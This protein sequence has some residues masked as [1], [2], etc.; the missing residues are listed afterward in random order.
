MRCAMPSESIVFGFWID[1]KRAGIVSAVRPLL[2]QLQSLGFR[3]APHTRAAVLK[4]TGSGS[5]TKASKT[6]TASPTLMLAQE[7]VDDLE[8]ALEQ[9][10]EIAVDLGRE[11]ITKESEQC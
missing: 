4:L 3:L 1:A 6:P 10:R 11:K 9:F 2:N 8:A 7:I 5:E